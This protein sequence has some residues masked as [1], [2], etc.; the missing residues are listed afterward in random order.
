MSKFENQLETIYAIDRQEWR[1]WLE[2]NHHF[3]KFNNTTKKNILFWIDSAKLP[4]TRLKRIEQTIESAAQNQKPL[5]RRGI[6]K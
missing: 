4:E 3:Q 2:N 5:A 6:P 1:K